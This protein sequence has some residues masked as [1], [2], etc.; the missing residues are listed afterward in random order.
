MK[1]FSPFRNQENLFTKMTINLYICH[2]H[3]FF[4]KS[5]TQEQQQ[6]DKRYRNFVNI[7]NTDDSSQG[8]FITCDTQV[9]VNF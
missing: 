2:I 3:V 1:Y 4:Q 7:F 5:L 9:N 8:E 6:M